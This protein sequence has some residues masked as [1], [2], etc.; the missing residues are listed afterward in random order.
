MGD[1]PECVPFSLGSGTAPRRLLGERT[2]V[3]RHRATHRLV[4]P[5]NPSVAAVRDKGKR[6]F[7]TGGFFVKYGGFI[8]LRRVDRKCY[9]PKSNLLPR[10]NSGELGRVRKHTH[11]SPGQRLCAK[12]RA[13]AGNGPIVRG[14]KSARMVE[15]SPLNSLEPG[16]GVAAARTNHLLYDERTERLTT[17]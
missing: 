15:R 11:G 12:R 14:L 6:E 8:R 16:R 9:R 5:S 10:T 7:A 3:A 4:V 17:N 2:G 13:G 1:K